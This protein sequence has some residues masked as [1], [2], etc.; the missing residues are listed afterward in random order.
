M[1]A[2][3]GV[4]SSTEALRLLER[5]IETARDGLFANAR[6]EELAEQLAAEHDRQA[7]LRQPEWHEFWRPRELSPAEY[8][9]QFITVGITDSAAGS[10]CAAASTLNGRNRS[11]LTRDLADIISVI[12]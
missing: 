8:K 5:E 1:A 12:R 7:R 6:G 11:V 2:G 4:L 3:I 10:G 9:A